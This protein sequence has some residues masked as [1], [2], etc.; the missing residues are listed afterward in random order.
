MQFKDE[1]EVQKEKLDYYFDS[2]SFT[3][4]HEEMLQDDVRTKAY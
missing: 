2:Y 1:E 3:G 4:I